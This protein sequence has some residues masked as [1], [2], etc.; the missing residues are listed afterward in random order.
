MVAMSTSGP[1]CE[2]C[3]GQ[4]PVGFRFCG[5]CGAAL[6]L[7]PP[8]PATGTTG[9]CWRCQ[10]AAPAGA[11]WCPVCGATLV[12]APTAATAGPP[13]PLPDAPPGGGV[14][15]REGPDAPSL[16]SGLVTV[17]LAVTIIVVLAL[18]GIAAG[19]AASG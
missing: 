11:A 9:T 8:P 4:N 6:A 5:S 2:R 18:I 12:V 17:L 3:G 15:V 1:V 7:P 10:T 13:G 16:G 19:R 14:E